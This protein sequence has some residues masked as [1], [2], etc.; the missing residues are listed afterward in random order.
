VECG[1]PLGAACAECG[2][3]NEPGDKFCGGCGHALAPAAPSVPAGNAPARHVA[4]VASRVAD[5][6]PRA[7]REPTEPE[8][9]QLTVMFCDLVGSTSLA[10]SLDPEDL[11]DVIRLYQQVTRSAVTRFGGFVARYMGDGILV[12]F[13]YP[14]AHEDDAERAVRS[15]LEVVSAVTGLDPPSLR[16]TGNRLA[17]RVG[18]ATGLVVVGD[19]IGEGASEESPVLGA[20]PNMAARLQKVARP[21]Q[22]VISPI[23]RRLVEGLFDFED[24]GAHELEGFSQPVQVSGVI[25]PRETASRFEAV[26]ETGITPLVGREEEVLALERRWERAKRCE[27]QV[28]LLSGEAGIGKSRIVRAMRDHV[29]SEEHFVL[30]YQCSPLHANSAL[31]P[32][33]EQFKHVAGITP[34]DSAERRLD[35]LEHLIQRV[36]PELRERT[37]LYAALLSIP[38]GER[39]PP[40]QMT[41]TQQRG[42]TF[43]ALV[44]LLDAVA[45]RTPVLAVIEDAHWVDP[46][47]QEFVDL[48]VQEASTRR[49]LVMVCARP[50][51]APGWIGQAHVSVMTLNR[52]DR[53]NSTALMQRVV[54]E[55]GLPPEVIDQIL[56][57]T[58]G[59]PLFVEDLT[60]MVLDSGLLVEA[61]DR[62]ELSGPLPALAIPATLHDAL[63]ARLDQLISVKRILQIGST[64][65]RE[66]S[67]ELLAAIADTDEQ[68]LRDALEELVRCELL[69]R[70]GAHPSADYAFKHALEQDAAYESQLRSQREKLHARIAST[71]ERRF[72]DVAETEP[73][74]LAHHYAAAGRAEAALPYWRRAAERAVEG[75]AHV[76]AAEHFQRG[77]AALEALPDDERRA[78]EEIVLLL[79]LAECLKT[80]GHG[81]E[82]AGALH[83]AAETA[84]RH[85]LSA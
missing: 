29:K 84:R 37:P 50:G 70:C 24:R 6:A 72:P 55:K 64:I 9:R 19:L 65:G 20:T 26:H 67:F 12:Y 46:S 76:E 18:I 33:I 34:E 74:T 41:A 54:G 44:S 61:P 52:L 21:N 58:D 66:F 3:L 53:K 73:E 4:R 2:F 31:Y 47:S 5:E 62:Y 63:M 14:R 17:V 32:F 68:S 27:G 23:T 45:A 71:L 7:R 43:T 83:R 11:R 10:A 28:V 30:A 81:T 35:K 42:Q 22:A 49:V 60:R 56:A 78:E 25:R 16:A 15:A 59:V 36:V 80:M 85:Q 69:I 77:L 8:R 51:Y 13:G 57:K 38:T 48:L 82:A 75:A 39:Y 79:P 1:A 40:L